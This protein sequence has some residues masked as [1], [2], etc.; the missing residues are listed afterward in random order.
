[1]RVPVAKAGRQVRVVD[2]PEMMCPRVAA[3]VRD[4]LPVIAFQQRY[5]PAKDLSEAPIA[6]LRDAEIPQVIHTE[7]ESG[8]TCEK[9]EPGSV[10]LDRMGGD[11]RQAPHVAP[12]CEGARC[13]MGSRSTCRRISSKDITA[14]TTIS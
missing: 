7:V 6:L 14:R 12:A 3:A 1:M 4:Q 13:G 11:D 5:V 10:I 2:S 9:P 8:T